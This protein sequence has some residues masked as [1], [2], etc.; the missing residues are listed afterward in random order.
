MPPSYRQR[1]R[2]GWASLW[3]GVGSSFLLLTVIDAMIFMS[4]SEL[5]WIG[6]SG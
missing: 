3:C 6:P 5:G 4:L 1:M 2:I